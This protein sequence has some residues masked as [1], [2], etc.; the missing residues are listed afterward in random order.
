VTS[1]TVPR[2]PA[3]DSGVDAVWSVTPRRT[4]LIR[5]RIHGRTLWIR[6]LR[7]VFRWRR[8]R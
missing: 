1:T 7:G 8:R 5:A 3:R 6:E 4:R 2:L